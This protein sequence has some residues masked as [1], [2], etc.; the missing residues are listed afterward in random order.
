MFSAERLSLSS[1]VLRTYEV[2]VRLEGS[3]RTI[4]RENERRATQ[5]IRALQQELRERVTPERVDQA[6]AYL[7]TNS[8]L[9]GTTGA[10][11]LA[12]LMQDRS[13]L[14]QAA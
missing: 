2:G 12:K 14:G 13:N 9:S 7:R 11:H 5:I 6:L 1:P 4:R 3:S 8:K 10:A